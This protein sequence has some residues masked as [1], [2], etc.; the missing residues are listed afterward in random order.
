MDAHGGVV[1]AIES[2]HFVAAVRVRRH[3]HAHGQFGQ[4]APRTRLDIAEVSICHRLSLP[5]AGGHPAEDGLPS[6]PGVAECTQSRCAC[7]GVTLE[8]TGFANAGEITAGTPGVRRRRHLR[9][10]TDPSARGRSSEQGQLVRAVPRLKPDIPSL[11]TRDAARLASEHQATAR[12][13]DLARS[14]ASSRTQDTGG[15]AT[16]DTPR[17]AAMSPVERPIYSS[18]RRGSIAIGWSRRHPSSRSG[19]CTTPF[20]G[21]RSRVEVSPSSCRYSSAAWWSDS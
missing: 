5:A 1:G 16:Y 4:P 21:P 6:H 11:P 17:R 9:L 13:E 19:A 3:D 10:A 14:T 7:E 20:A 12:H 18:R 15:L 8:V 2:R